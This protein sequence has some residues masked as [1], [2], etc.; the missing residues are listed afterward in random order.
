MVCFKPCFRW[1][2]PYTGHLEFRK[3]EFDITSFK[4]C[5]RWSAPYTKKMIFL[6]TKL[7][8]VLNLVLDGR[9]LIQ[10]IKERLK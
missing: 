10:I 5:F 2:A 7:L 8:L 3:W 9:I 4:P 1:S 6:L